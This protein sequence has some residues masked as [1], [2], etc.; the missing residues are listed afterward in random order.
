VELIGMRHTTYCLQFKVLIQTNKNLTY[1]RRFIQGQGT[2]SSRYKC[3]RVYI[4]NKH[5]KGIEPDNLLITNDC[6][7]RWALFS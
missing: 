7:L 1:I 4:V 3:T 5:P 2:H 6:T